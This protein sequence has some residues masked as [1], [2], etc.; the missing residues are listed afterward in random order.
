[1]EDTEHASYDPEAV[2]RYWRVLSQVNLVLEEFAAEFS[3]KTSPVHH[4]WHTFDIAVTRYGARRLHQPRDAGP[5]IREAYSREAISFGFWFG[6]DNVPEPAFYSYTVPEPSGLTERPLTPSSAWW[7]P[8]GHGHLAL[9][10]YGRVRT[11]PDPRGAVLAFYESAYRAGAE[12]SGWDHAGL[13]SPKGVT[14]P[15]YE[16]GEET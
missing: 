13:A 9:L 8:S 11:E 16:A 12:L 6:D 1:M 14:D 4:F 3:G 5:I 2:T 15:L 10:P 7:A